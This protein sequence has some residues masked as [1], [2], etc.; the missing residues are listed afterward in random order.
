MFVLYI[1]VLRSPQNKTKT[2]CSTTCNS[3]YRPIY[4][5]YMSKSQMTEYK[6]VF[7]PF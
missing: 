5:K 3:R 7:Q 1:N 4:Q 6:N 2:N